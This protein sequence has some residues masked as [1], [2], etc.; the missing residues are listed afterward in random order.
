[1]DYNAP[2]SIS[3]RKFVQSKCMYLY[4]VSILLHV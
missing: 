4:V 2:C 3:T 1:M